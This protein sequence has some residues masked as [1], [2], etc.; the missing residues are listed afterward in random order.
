MQGS[1]MEHGES[2]GS[3]SVAAVS[4]REKTKPGSEQGCWQSRWTGGS[5]EAKL[6]APDL[7]RRPRPKVP[8]QEMGESFD[9]P[10]S[11]GMPGRLL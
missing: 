6:E 11:N 7:R 4:M 8:R 2:T 5:R 9:R 10:S 1:E 3:R